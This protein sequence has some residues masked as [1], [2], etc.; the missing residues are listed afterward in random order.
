MG[1][2]TTARRAVAKLTQGKVHWSVHVID[3]LAGIGI[4]VGGL[5]VILAVVGL[6]AFIFWQVV[7]LFA[8]P[9][10]G[11]LEA[12]GAP[13]A[14]ATLALH[15]DEYRRV[16]VRVT[17]L[18]VAAFVVPTGESLGFT[19]VPE[20]GS[21]K[22]TAA[23]IALRPYTKV[24]QDGIADVPRFALTLGLSDGR[25]LQGYVSYMH[26]FRRF[27]LNK[28]PE[29]WRKLPM[30]EREEFGK[31]GYV[32]QV[33]SESEDGKQW[34]IEHLAEFGF[35][36]RIAVL[37]AIERTLEIDA[38]GQVIARVYSSLSKG[39]PE[40][41][42]EALTAVITEKGRA[43]L[44]LEKLALNAMTEEVEGEKLSSADFT[45]HIKNKAAFCLCHDQHHDVLFATEEGLVYSFER[46]EK[47]NEFKP[48]SEPATNVFAGHEGGSWGEYVSAQCEELELGAATGAL[49]LT[50][51]GYLL[52]DTSVLLGDSHGG[53]QS[54]FK[55]RRHDEDINPQLMRI[56]VFEPGAGAVKG[57]A[58]CAANKSFLTWDDG[59]MVRVFHNTAERKVFEER[60]ALPGPAAM[61]YGDK[62]QGALAVDASGKLRNWWIDS[63]H[64][65]VSFKTLFGKVWYEGYREPKYEWQSSSGTDDVEPKYSMIPLIIGTLKGGMYALLFAIPLAVLGA[66]YTSEFMH[67][68]LRATIKPAMEVMASLPSVVLG[69]LGALY[70]APLAAPI[71]P[72]LLVMVVLCPTLFLLF[73]WMWQ[74]LPPTITGKFGP[75]ATLGLLFVLLLV[76][77]WGSTL[78]GPRAEPLLFSAREAAAPELVSADNFKPINEKTATRL[79]AGDLR[80]WTSGGALLQR[81]QAGTLAG[82][83]K[84]Q[85]VNLPKGWWLP[86]GHGLFIVLMTIPFALLVAWCVRAASALLFGGKIGKREFK[87]VAPGANPV[88]RVRRALAGESRTTLWPIAVDVAFSLGFV[89]L[90]VLAGWGVSLLVSPG[91]EYMLF[92]YEHPTAGGFVNGVATPARVA[93]FRRF[94]TGAEGWKFNQT[95]SLVVGFAMGFAV[96]PIIYSIAEDALSTVPN[97]LR[98]ASLACGASRWQTTVHVVVPAAASGIF[99]A[100]VIGLGRAIG[101]TMIVVMAAGGTPVT[102]MEPLSGFRSLSAAIAIEMPEAPHGG[103]HYRTLFLGGLMLFCMTFVISSMAELVRMRLRKKLSRM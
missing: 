103:S 101:E 22:V 1:S 26:A 6:V 31:P 42:R 13:V 60:I 97:Q 23:Q 52:G 92:G 20:L 82:E 80:S 83:G 59:G 102:A 38:G 25:V 72:T 46:D 36:R 34:M 24:L 30:P 5:T 47:T 45:G 56:H 96:I 14:D 94:I 29:S 87:G 17:P 84:T 15:T 91:I 50:A 75:L 68:K 85:A 8:M 65:E 53:V 90:V 54:W 11:E 95:N 62:A 41:E 51:M 67:R 48:N 37:V 93:D 71:M 55:V 76:G 7:P 35:Y 57:F 10:S 64:S 88:D 4:R 73:G 98:A 63:K 19:P 79:D 44:L 9:D 21:A 43:L 99:S 27:E 69:F 28:D 81:E 70:F 40:A 100:I 49:K 86:G 74:Q 33:L 2:E 32:P 78:I 12:K 18:G 61:H 16:G 39:E 77:I 89:G 66:I 58:A 3:R